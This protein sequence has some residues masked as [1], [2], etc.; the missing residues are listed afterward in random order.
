MGNNNVFKYDITNWVQDKNALL[1]MMNHHDIPS[2]VIG[3]VFSI[4]SLFRQMILIMA[5][6][7]NENGGFDH[8]SEE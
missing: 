2:Q 7:T 4:L 5:L 6:E 8:K 3:D 1:F